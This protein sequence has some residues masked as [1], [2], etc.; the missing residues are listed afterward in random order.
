MGEES[1]KISINYA[2]KTPGHNFKSELALGISM[3]MESQGE[4]RT[5]SVSVM[6]P[7]D[8]NELLTGESGSALR[9]K[10]HLLDHSVLADRASIRSRL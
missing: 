3:Q 1:Y 9:K 8:R 4:R 5:R 2:N 10:K 7:A 6:K